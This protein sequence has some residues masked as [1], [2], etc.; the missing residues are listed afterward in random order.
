[1]VTGAASANPCLTSHLARRCKR[2]TCSGPV[3]GPASLVDGVVD[4]GGA[5]TGVV[6]SRHQATGHGGP[7][8]DARPR[9]SGD[10]WEAA[11]RFAGAAAAAGR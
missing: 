2:S 3:A 5:V 9:P 6:A 4:G 1:M 10:P 7:A 11:S 8:P